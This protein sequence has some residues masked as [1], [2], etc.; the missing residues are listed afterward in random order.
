MSVAVANVA[1]ARTP[2]VIASVDI[3]LVV[4]TFLSAESR[5]VATTLFPPTMDDGVRTFPIVS[6]CS[7]PCAR[8]FKPTVNNSV[9]VPNVYP[10]V[11][12]V[13][14]LLLGA[15]NVIVGALFT[16]DVS[17]DVDAPSVKRQPC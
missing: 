12:A 3:E 6:T 14:V 5:V 13:G 8:S 1:D 9:R 7:V 2:A 16:P 15:V 4:S 11:V 17:V 10:T